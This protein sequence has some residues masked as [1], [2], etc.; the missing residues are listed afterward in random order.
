MQPWEDKHIEELLKEAASQAEFKY[1]DSNWAALN[2]KLASAQALNNAL[3]VGVLVVLV[4]IGYLGYDLLK[5]ENYNEEFVIVEE[6]ANDNIT[7]PESGLPM[8][9]AETQKSGDSNQLKKKPVDGIPIKTKVATTVISDDLNNPERVLRVDPLTELTKPDV[10][11]L[12]PILASNSILTSSYGKMNFKEPE[13]ILI[14]KTKDYPFLSQRK[15]GKLYIGLSIASDF[16]GVQFSGNKPGIAGGASFGYK[17]SKKF[18]IQ[19][20]INFSK[21]VYNT[22]AE[23]Y[24]PYFGYWAIY[25][26]PEKI[27]ANCTVLDIPINLRYN[28]FS[29]SA[30]TFFISSGVSSYFM[31]AE[32]YY[33][34]Y[35][36]YA[37]RPTDGVSLKSGNKHL[38][39]VVNLSIGLE[40]QLTPRL[41]IEIEPYLKIPTAGIGWGNVDLTTSGVNFTG[42]FYFNQ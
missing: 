29:Y 24:Q 19:T 13:P 32:N 17:I 12:K 41:G 16:S 42:K 27:E 6:L 34:G 40:K 15:T 20:G 39:S 4:L 14:T 1:D 5:G 3:K 21:K 11:S 30:S 7:E 18:Q 9:D 28:V 35:R 8:A 26:T 36:F 33:Y 31:L 37:E 25:E 23:H 2:S 38:F 10:L 22:L